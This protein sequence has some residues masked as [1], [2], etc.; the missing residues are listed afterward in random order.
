MKLD[1]FT[2]DFSE[3]EW[4]WF[5]LHAYRF[6]D[7]WS[8]FIVET[9]E[10]NWLRRRASTTMEYAAIDRA[11]RTAVRRASRR[12][13]PRLERPAPARVVSLAQVQPRALRASGIT[14]NIVLI[15]DAAHTAHFSIGSGTKLAMEDAIALARVLSEHAGESR[16]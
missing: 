8:T 2:F 5:N 16:T 6:D 7:D 11:L 14:S 1:A 9:P 12:P 3:T 4:G 15:G 13:A 10:T